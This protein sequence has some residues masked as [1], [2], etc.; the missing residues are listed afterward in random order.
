MGAPHD[1]CVQPYLQVGLRNKKISGDHSDQ[2]SGYKVVKFAV[3][4]PFY[5]LK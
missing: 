4:I 5:L 1:L 3:F 2:N